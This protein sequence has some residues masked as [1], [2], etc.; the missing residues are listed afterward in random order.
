MLQVGDQFD[1]FQ[2]RA[3]VVQSGTA[4][5]YAATDLLS[6]RE[7]AVK[8]PHRDLLSDPTQ[9]ERFRRELEVVRVLNHPA[10]QKGLESGVFDKIPYLITEWVDGRLMR[11]VV[12]EEAPMPIPKALELIRKIADGVV[13]CHENGVIHRDLKPENILITTEGQ[14]V[15]MDFGLVLTKDARRV[16]Y[17]NVSGTSGTPD[18]MSPERFEGQRG[19]KRTDIYALGVMLYELIAGRTPYYGDN[20][21]IVISQHQKA[22]IPR[23]D[24]EVRG[25]SPQLA[26]VVTRALQK[27][28]DDRY[29][30]VNSFLSALDNLEQV[31][32]TLLDKNAPASS[33]G[34]PDFLKTQQGK[35]AIIVGLL[36]VAALIV[37]VVASQVR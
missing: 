37:A 7:V 27:N 13:Y 33:T 23:L 35:I 4:D 26:A 28:P 16:T 30:D 1:H 19:D 21:M 5:I 6:G 25:A 17:A 8:I 10:V 15:I 29:P 36:V 24:Q 11:D 9:A 12:A 14:P 18:Y 20:T 3:H 32:V 34:L 22:P 31:D 2:I